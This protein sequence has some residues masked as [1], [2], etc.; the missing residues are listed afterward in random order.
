MARTSLG[1]TVVI[2][3]PIDGSDISSAPTNLIPAS[4][5]QYPFSKTENFGKKIGDTPVTA[6]FLEWQANSAGQITGFHAWVET[7]GSSASVTIDLKKNGT[8][9]CGGGPITLTNATTAG[10]RVNGSVT[11]PSFVA[12]DRFSMSMVVSS[13]T[14]MAGVAATMN[15]VEFGQPL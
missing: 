2:T 5:I 8:T 4:A 6:E 12:G 10:T 11:V 7:P 14:G 3:Y 15:G 13:S 1:N 9:V